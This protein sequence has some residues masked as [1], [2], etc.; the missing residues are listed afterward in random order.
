MG[1]LELPFTHCPR[2]EALGPFRPRHR[3]VDDTYIE[4]FIRCTTCNWE[5]I[6]RLS[7]VEIERLRRLKVKWE[8]YNRAS[9]ARYGVPSA[10]A[11]AQLRK[12]RHRLRELEDEIPD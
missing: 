11:A 6:L 12:I 1:E 9:H 7:T 10:M 2:C 4:V 5:E 3:S 8:A